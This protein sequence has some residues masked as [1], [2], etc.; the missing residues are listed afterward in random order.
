MPVEARDWYDRL[1]SLARGIPDVPAPLLVSALYGSGRRAAQLG[2][3]AAAVERAEEVLAL[4]ARLGDPVRETLGALSILC[5]VAE[6]RGERARLRGLL[7]ASLE[8]AR[9]GQDPHRE[10]VTLSNLAD[11]VRQEGDLERAAALYS[12]CLGIG[13]ATD[14]DSLRSMA[15]IN[16][17]KVALKRGD[18]AAAAPLLDDGLALARQLGALRGVADTQVALGELA[19]RQL[20]TDRARDCFREAFELYR[21]SRYSWLAAEALEHLAALFADLGHPDTATLL[22]AATCAVHHA[23][24]LPDPEGREEYRGLA[25]L[26]RERVGAQ[27]FA[28][29]WTRGLGMAPL[30]VVEVALEALG[31]GRVHPEPAGRK[32]HRAQPQALSPRQA[33]IADLLAQGHTNVEIA[34]ALG[35]EKRT[36]DAHVGAILARLGVSSRA[37]VA[38]KLLRQ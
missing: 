30:E 32:T 14:D 36:V 8:V 4:C 11:Y 2:D 21:T 25:A 6:L 9:V 17:G 24:R 31:P 1:L 27:R 13:Q 34:V 19:Q 37:E 29:A 26:L 12:E 22:L 20:A 10:A 3:V 38:A 7:E 35:I 33:Q 28:E 23:A 5:D 16:L 18:L 15:L